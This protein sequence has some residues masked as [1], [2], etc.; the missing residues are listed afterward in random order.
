MSFFFF[1]AEFFFPSLFVFSHLVLFVAGPLL[2]PLR[3][4]F[5]RHL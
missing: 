4:S 1:G 2:S 5:F 3:S